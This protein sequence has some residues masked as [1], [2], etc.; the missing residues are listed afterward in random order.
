M[1][2]SFV[3][4]FWEPLALYEVPALPKKESGCIFEEQISPV[5]TA[6]P[7]VPSGHCAC[8][9]WATPGCHLPTSRIH[10]GCLPKSPF[11][12]FSLNKIPLYCEKSPGTQ[13]QRKP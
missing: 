5:P 2:C 9:E 1:I 6:L 3:P 12:V 4:G 13:T 8:Y 11:L 10:L 7:L